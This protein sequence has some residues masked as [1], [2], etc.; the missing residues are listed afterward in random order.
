MF[1]WNKFMTFKSID[2]VLWKGDIQINLF[3]FLKRVGYVR[4]M[5]QSRTFFYDVIG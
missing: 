2:S 3:C 4:V 1:D 5:Y